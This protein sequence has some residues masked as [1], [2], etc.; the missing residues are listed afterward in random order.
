MRKAQKLTFKTRQTTN[1]R[2]TF[3]R[4]SLKRTFTC[5]YLEHAP[6]GDVNVALHAWLHSYIHVL[7]FSHAFLHNGV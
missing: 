1:Q 3:E 6:Q 2:R 5:V 4:R 7:T